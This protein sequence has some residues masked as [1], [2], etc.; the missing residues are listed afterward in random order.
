MKELQFLRAI[1]SVAFAT[2]ED[3]LPH[4]RIIDVMLIEN[5][6]IYFTTARGKSFYRQLCNTSYVALVGMDAN[7]KS[8]R[9]SGS[10]KKAERSFVDK[11][12]IENP[13]MNDIYPGQTR[14]ILEAFCI[15][16]GV[17]EIFDLSESSPKRSRFTFGGCKEILPGYTIRD[18][19]IACNECIDS[20]PENAI[21]DDLVINREACID[22]GRCYEICPADAIQRA[23]TFIAD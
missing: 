7:Y 20:C 21:S 16:K 22:C 3:G 6:K 15:F 9:I 5:D 23:Q 17:G 18:N 10:V 2:V 19:C 4:A 1:K 12:F 14:D 13:M 8:I 11:I